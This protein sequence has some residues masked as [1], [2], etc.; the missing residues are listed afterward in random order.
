MTILIRPWILLSLSL[1]LFVSFVEVAPGAEPCVS[2]LSPGQ[3]PGPYTFVM[4][5]GPQRGQLHCYI[6]ET[7]DKPAVDIFARNLSDPLGKLLRGVDKALVD[8]KTAELRA[9]VT[10]LHEDQSSIDA[11]VVDWGKKHAV[12]GVPLGVFEDAGGP[13]SYRLAKD[14][15]VTVLLSVKQ[16][17]VANFAFRAG[18]LTDEKIA[19][20]L[21]A[22]P[23]ITG[24]K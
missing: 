7:A 1:C 14:A 17:V 18:E 22:V 3:R 5:T 11:K 13:P 21:K 12:R 16:K 2:G 10:F 9:W 8:H 24:G 4:S 19:E 23:Q 15:D 20:V 6:C